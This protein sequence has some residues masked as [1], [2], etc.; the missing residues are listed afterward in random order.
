VEIDQQQ[1]SGQPSPAEPKPV[2]PLL[3]VHSLL[4]G[5]YWLAILLAIVGAAIGTPIGYNSVKPIYKSSGRIEFHLQLQALMYETEQNGPIP[6]FDQF[7][8]ARIASMKSTKEVEKAMHDAYWSQ[9][10][11]GDSI[12]AV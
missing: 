4:R 8:Q 11:R 6:Y 3:V 7:I 10:G 5:R 9:L 2:N 1:H 12:D